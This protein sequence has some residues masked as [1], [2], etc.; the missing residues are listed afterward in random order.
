MAESE[1]YNAENEDYKR[2]GGETEITGDDVAG[3]EGLLEIEIPAA[4]YGDGKVATAQDSD[5]IAGNIKKD[6]VIFGVT[7]TAE[8]SVIHEAVFFPKTAGDDG[9][10]VAGSLTTSSDWISIGKDAGGSPRNTFLR[11]AA[12]TIPAD[13]TITECFVRF[14][15]Y[16][17]ANNTTVRLNCYFNNH[18]NAVAPADATAY[19]TLSLTA[20][21]SWDSLAAWADGTQYDTPELKTIL[22]TVI[23]RDGW[24]EDQ[25]VMVVINN[26]DGGQQRKPR[27]V[28]V[29]L[30][31]RGG[32][33]RASR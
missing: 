33:C 13:A 4:R 18:D 31:K 28:R 3:D 25:A 15:A 10:L 14:T 19:G 27:S 23:D 8:A 16:C 20:A 7:G 1:D 5:L 24:A 9:G 17:A 26:D 29:R 6:V 30:R 12:V 2:R 32:A 22:Q 11:F 21:I